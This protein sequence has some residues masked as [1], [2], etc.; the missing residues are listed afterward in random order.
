M[1]GPAERAQWRS[2]ASLADHFAKHGPKL[3]LINE[4]EYDASGRETMRSGRRFTYEDRG[5]GEPRVGYFDR[6][7]GL[8]VALTADESTLLTHFATDDEY[9]RNLPA[10]TYP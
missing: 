3:G 6:R 2:P 10:S 8:L 9:V 4:G 7:S 5:S 1:S